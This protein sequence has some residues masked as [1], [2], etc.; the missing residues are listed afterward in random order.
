MLVSPFL[1]ADNQRKPSRPALVHQDVCCRQRLLKGLGSGH[2]LKCLKGF[3][4]HDMVQGGGSNRGK[5][6]T[7]ARVLSDGAPYNSSA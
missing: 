2:K 1:W 4:V 6:I 3:H 5:A 7:C